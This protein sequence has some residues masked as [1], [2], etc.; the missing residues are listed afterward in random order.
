MSAMSKDDLLSFLEKGIRPDGR[1]LQGSRAPSISKGPS[2]ASGLS[3][4]VCIGATSVLAGLTLVESEPHFTCPKKGEI[5]VKTTVC[6]AS[7]PSNHSASG[8]ATQWKEDGASPFAEELQRIV[9]K[10]VLE[11]LEQFCIEEG[12]RVWK[13][14]INIVAL[15][16]DGALFDAALLAIIAAMKWMKVPVIHE[17]IPLK[18]DGEST[19]GTDMETEKGNGEEQKSKPLNVKDPAHCPIPLTLGVIGGKILSDLNALET[20]HAESSVTILATCNGQICGISKGNGNG[21]MMELDSLNACFDIAFDRA[22]RVQ[23]VLR[24]I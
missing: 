3:A 14:L 4:Q 19:P 13:L 23:E 5:E 11:D 1:Q 21:E 9:S 24:S 16:D 22:K 6:N 15:S 10:E 2:H 17:E 18:M 20:R 8:T 7:S 12:K